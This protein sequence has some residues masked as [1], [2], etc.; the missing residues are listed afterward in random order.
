ME[1]E[2][3][4]INN[5]HNLIDG[6]KLFKLK[7]NKDQRG[8]LTETFKT[9][10]PDIYSEDFPFA[11]S[12][13]SITNPGYARDEDRW[14]FHPTKQTDRF[15]VVKGSAVF[16]LYDSRKASKTFGILNLFLT[17]EANGDDG[18]YL[19]VIP[20][21]VLHGFCV[22]SNEPCYLISYISTLYDPKEEGRL[23][24][25]ESGVK[26]P[27]GSPFSWNTIRKHFEK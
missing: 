1:L 17:G 4:G 21:E 6:V 15:V 18:Q 25:S 12:Y 19:L 9:N 14:H 3:L 7:V 20:R 10:W 24:F 11:Q 16:A 13:C 2:F 22:V 23:L 27:D 26:L 5:Q 8:S